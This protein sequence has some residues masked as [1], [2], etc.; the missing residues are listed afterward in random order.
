VSWSG[1]A[2]RRHGRAGRAT[3]G[4]RGE[5]TVTVPGRGAVTPEASAVSFSGVGTFFPGVGATGRPAEEIALGH[6]MGC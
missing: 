6:T 5:V 4:P 1:T 2:Q 3:R